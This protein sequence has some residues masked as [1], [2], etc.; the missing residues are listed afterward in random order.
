M[1]F[2]RN[3]NIFILD[4]IDVKIILT[5]YQYPVY[6]SKRFLGLTQ[7]IIFCMGII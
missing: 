2:V 1:S 3:Y 4:F 5:I 6:Q 7:K